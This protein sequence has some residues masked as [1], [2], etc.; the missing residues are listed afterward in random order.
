[1]IGARLLACASIRA[2]PD[3]RVACVAMRRWSC[4]APLPTSDIA[5]L[6]PLARGDDA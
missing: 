5:P 2:I 6:A 4:L 3:R 1:M